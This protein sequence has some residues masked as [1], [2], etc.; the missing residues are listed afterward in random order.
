MEYTKQNFKS[1]QILTAE[2]LNNMD[3]SLESAVNELNNK[4]EKITD[5]SIP[6]SA[7]A[8]EVKNKIENAG[9][10]WEAKEGEAGFIKNKPFTLWPS[11]WE[12]VYFNEGDEYEW[13]TDVNNGVVIKVRFNGVYEKIITLNYN[14]LRKGYTISV[15]PYLEGYDTPIPCLFVSLILDGSDR[16]SIQRIDPTDL[17]E[18]YVEV[19]NM[20]DLKRLDGAYIDDTVLK[21]T[22]Q[23]LS[24]NDKNQ[25]LANL[26]IDPV[27]WKYIC[28]PLVIENGK[29]VPEELIGEYVDH[30]DDMPTPSFE[31]GYKLK[32]PNL[33]MYKVLFKVGDTSI[34]SSFEGYDDKGYLY[35]D[36]FTDYFFIDSK[37]KWKYDR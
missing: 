6:L 13:M 24:N 22:P 12:G 37:K 35:Y 8:T 33:G 21:T 3:S 20:S 7:L 10:D 28:N 15:L 23:E 9:A 36:N 26:G 34:V 16:V 11:P 25:A 29:P 32:Y 2:A 5:G 17:N 27:V 18:V 1:G 19:F 30:G 14:A 31:K 4:Q